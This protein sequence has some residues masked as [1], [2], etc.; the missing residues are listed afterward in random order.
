VTGAIEAVAIPTRSNTRNAHPN[1]TLTNRDN[2]AYGLS[3]HMKIS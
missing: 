2:E 3:A 1:K